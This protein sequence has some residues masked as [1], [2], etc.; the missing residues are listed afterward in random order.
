MRSHSSG[1]ILS[2]LFK[3]HKLSTIDEVVLLKLSF[4]RCCYGDSDIQ[5]SRVFKLY[6]VDITRF[7]GS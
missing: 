1:Y 5:D 4:T 7:L 3:K 2:L 6:L